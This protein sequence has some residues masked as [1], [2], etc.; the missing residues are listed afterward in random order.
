MK[1]LLLSSVVL[2]VMLSP[3]AAESFSGMFVA[4]KGSVLLFN[5]ATLPDLTKDTLGV[6]DPKEYGG[7]GFNGW[8]AGA[9]LGYSFRFAN[10]FVI[11]LS[12]GGGYKHHTLKEARDKETTEGKKKLG[13][14]FITSGLAADA[15][16]RLGMAFGRFHI[17]LNPGLE[18][19]MSNP[20]L[21]VAYKGAGDKDETHKITYATDKGPEWKERLSF[22]IGLNV[23]YA[24]TQTMFLGGGVGY[25]YSFA[26]VK[27]MKDNFSDDTKAKSSVVGDISYKNP[28][29]LEFGVIV[30]ASF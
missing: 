5:K 20:E 3:V 15:R 13:L 21:T 25:R 2:T 19:G 6:D 26:E 27:S 11:G 29:G 1:K 30:G 14:D 9:E 18:L 22:V 8:N 10:N 4:G 7:F 12:V 28:M 16:L 23:E 24:V 17:Y